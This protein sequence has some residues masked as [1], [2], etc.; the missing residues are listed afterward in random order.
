MKLT[1][2][3]I[4]SIIS[5]LLYFIILLFYGY[6]LNI[7]YEPIHTNTK[8]IYSFILFLTILVPIIINI[9]ILNFK[10]SNIFLNYGQ[11]LFCSLLLIITYYKDDILIMK[12]D[13]INNVYIDTIEYDNRGNKINL[14][15]DNPNYKTRVKAASE[16]SN[17]RSEMGRGIYD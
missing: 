11:L 9:Y 6:K 8:R 17:R 15:K 5:Y 12:F 4:I 3:E 13:T 14:K 10:Y 1:F 7:I 16:E 2:F